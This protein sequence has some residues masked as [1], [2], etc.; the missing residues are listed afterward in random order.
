MGN[1]RLLQGVTESH[2]HPVIGKADLTFCWSVLVIWSLPF[3]RGSM[4]MLWHLRLGNM[5]RAV[6][7]SRRLFQALGPT[8]A[9]LGAVNEA[10]CDD[11]KLEQNTLLGRDTMVSLGTVQKR[12]HFSMTHWVSQLTN[13][14]DGENWIPFTEWFCTHSSPFMAWDLTSLMMMMQVLQFGTGFCYRG[15]TAWSLYRISTFLLMSI[16]GCNLHQSFA[17]RPI[18]TWRTHLENAI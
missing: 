7:V 13:Y 11:D 16:L 9:E 10:L 12:K 14:K 1:N 8:V 15:R 4:T 5:R 3:L 17:V 6:F 2:G 18:R